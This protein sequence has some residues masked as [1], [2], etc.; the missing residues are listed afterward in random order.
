MGV[1]IKSIIMGGYMKS[2]VFGAISISVIS[3][4]SL[5]IGNSNL[6]VIVSGTLGL[7]SLVLG[8]ITSGVMSDDIHR[9]IAT[10]SS[11]DRMNRLD[12]STTLFLFGL[13]NIIGLSIYLFAFYK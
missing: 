1:V 2:F 12:K 7:G 3:L 5:I 9:R 13:P 4:I 6:F 11:V 10:E 8:G